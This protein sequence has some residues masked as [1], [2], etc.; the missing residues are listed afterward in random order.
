MTA[1]MGSRI[2]HGMSQLSELYRRHGFTAL[3]V[4]VN[5]HLIMIGS[6][7]ASEYFAPGNRVQRK[8]VERIITI[9]GS[10][11]FPDDLRGPKVTQPV[12]S[13]KTGMQ[14]PLMNSS[15]A[16]PVPVPEPPD[17]PISPVGAN[18]SADPKP[19]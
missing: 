16:I 9:L 19:G 11:Q 10:P 7:Y 3:T 13:P 15:F 18:D 17:D 4:A 5:I 8:D 2:Q 14:R 6:Y 1:R 12:R